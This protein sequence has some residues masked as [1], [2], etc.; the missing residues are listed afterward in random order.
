MAHFPCYGQNL[1][2]VKLTHSKVL[3]EMERINADLKQVTKH[4]VPVIDW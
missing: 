4:N 1:E 2:V 3:D